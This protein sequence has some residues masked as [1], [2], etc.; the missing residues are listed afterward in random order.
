MCIY[1]RIMYC[2][3]SLLILDSR[4]IFCAFVCWGLSLNFHVIGFGLVAKSQLKRERHNICTIRIM[5]T[6]S[7]QGQHRS[8]YTGPKCKFYHAHLISPYDPPPP[9]APRQISL[10]FC[11]TNQQS[12]MMV[13]MAFS[14]KRAAAAVSMHVYSLPTQQLAR[15]TFSTIRRSQTTHGRTQRAAMAPMMVRCAPA[16]MRI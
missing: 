12:S 3:V 9:P 10:F 8:G 2:C 4:T 1:I 14:S 11:F 7:F 13:R 6:P 5:N 15:S 16:T